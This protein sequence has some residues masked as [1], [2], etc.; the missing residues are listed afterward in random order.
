MKQSEIHYRY[1]DDGITVSK[2]KKFSLDFP[3][4]KCARHSGDYIIVTN[5]LGQNIRVDKFGIKH[6]S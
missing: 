1:T 3:G 2:A 5:S 6:F 4:A